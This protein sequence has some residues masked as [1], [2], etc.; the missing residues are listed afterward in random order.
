MA[1]SA[2]T[3]RGHSIERIGHG[4]KALFQT[5]INEK[6]WSAATENLVKVGIDTWIDQGIEPKRS[7]H[8][9]TK[10]SFVSTCAI[11]T[12]RRTRLGSI[13]VRLMTNEISL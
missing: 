9:K 7:N 8:F 11:S 4:K 5:T 2:Y 13:V 6:E 12:K 1:K 3:Y 10:G